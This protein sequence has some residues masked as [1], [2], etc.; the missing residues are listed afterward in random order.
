[1]PG[2]ARLDVLGVVQH[3]MARGL[4]GAAIF[5]DEKDR[6]MF[7]GVTGGTLRRSSANEKNI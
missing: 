2:M 4:K 3:V 7:L 6:E 1:M 5:R